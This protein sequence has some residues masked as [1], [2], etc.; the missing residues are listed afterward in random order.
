MEAALRKCFLRWLTHNASRVLYWKKGHYAHCMITIENATLYI[1]ENTDFKKFVPRQNFHL[2]VNC[3]RRL[4]SL[5]F[6][7]SLP[8]KNQIDMLHHYFIHNVVYFIS[9][10]YVHT[11]SLTQ[12]KGT[13]FQQIRLIKNREPSVLAPKINDY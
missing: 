13:Y 1:T 12:L 6:P 2:F 8:A 10:A 5:D 11:N 9:R 4:F 3:F 7:S